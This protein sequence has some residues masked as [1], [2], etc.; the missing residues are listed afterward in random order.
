MLNMTSDFNFIYNPP[1]FFCDIP[2]CP[3]NDPHL[4]SN[5]KRKGEAWNEDKV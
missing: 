3:F 2:N 1:K 5:I 4:H